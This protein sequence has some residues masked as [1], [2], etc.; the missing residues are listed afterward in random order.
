M[1][2]FADLLDA[3]SEWLGYFETLNNGKPLATSQSEDLPFTAQTYR[4]FAGVCDKI[5]GNTITMAKP[6]FGMTKK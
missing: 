6:F 2:K 4:Y 5:K 3:S 1:N